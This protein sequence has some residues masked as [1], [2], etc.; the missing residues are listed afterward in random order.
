[1]TEAQKFLENLLRGILNVAT[2]MFISV[3]IIHII[4]GDLTVLY[5]LQ[6]TFA[7]FV[8]QVFW[9]RLKASWLKARRG[10]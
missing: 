3:A 4:G 1:M 8:V 10:K 9:V 6:L 5:V 7:N 2:T